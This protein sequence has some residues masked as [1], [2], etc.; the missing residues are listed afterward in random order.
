MKGMVAITL[1]GL[2]GLLAL[3]S[4]SNKGISEGTQGGLPTH[5][6]IVKD[7]SFDPVRVTAVRNSTFT[8]VN[9]SGATI[10]IY[11]QD[12]IV[13]NKQNIAANTSY[14]FTKDTVGTIIYRMAGKPT[15]TGSIVITP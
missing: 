3:Q 4:C 9:H 10:G 15:V 11:S 6:I 7:G 13:I 12:S 8:F 14:I 1:F 5:Y 2:I